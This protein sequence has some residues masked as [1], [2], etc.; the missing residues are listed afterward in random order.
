MPAM[1]PQKPIFTDFKCVL[2]VRLIAEILMESLLI[3]YN[4]NKDKKV[5]HYCLIFWPC[6]ENVFRVNI[7]LKKKCILF[8]LCP[9]G[10]ISSCF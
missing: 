4:I 6:L 8:I 9:H 5:L 7:L 10:T 1:A 2:G 3:K